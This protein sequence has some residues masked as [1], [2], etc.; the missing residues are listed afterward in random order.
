MF[1]NFTL[2][3]VPRVATPAPGPGEADSRVV[4]VHTQDTQ[5]PGAAAEEESS[6]SAAAANLHLSDI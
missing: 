3:R 1:N 2:S 6:R 4:M 5:P